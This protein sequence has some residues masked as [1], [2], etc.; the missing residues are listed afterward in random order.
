MIP[1]VAV[2]L[3]IQP[4]QKRSKYALLLIVYTDCYSINVV[5]RAIEL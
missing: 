4:E 1:G 2:G 5:K 3:A